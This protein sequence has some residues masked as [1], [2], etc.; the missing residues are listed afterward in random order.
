MLHAF[1]FSSV[2]YYIKLL[3]NY[4]SFELS[5]FAVINKGTR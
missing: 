4:R 3:V 5:P 1:V 2:S